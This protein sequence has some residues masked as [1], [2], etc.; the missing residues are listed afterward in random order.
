MKRTLAP[1]IT[2]LSPFNLAFSKSLSEEQLRYYAMMLQDINP[3]TLGVAVNYLVQHAKFLPTIAE[4]RE[5][6]NTVSNNVNCIDD[7]MTSAEAWERTRKVAETWGYE[8]GL[9]HLEGAVQQT[10]KTIWRELCY[11]DVSD[12]NQ[13][14]ARFMNAYREFCHRSQQQ[15]CIDE[16]IHAIPPMMQTKQIKAEEKKLLDSNATMLPHTIHNDDYLQGVVLS[17]DKQAMLDAILKRG[18]VKEI[19]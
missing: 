10:A 16:L 2:Q 4:I 5:T 6:C 7:E 3:I 14:R 12:I 9:Q 13:T 11:G 17:E 15:A 19:K 8:H 18:L 1:W